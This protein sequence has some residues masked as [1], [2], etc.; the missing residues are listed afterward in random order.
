M[1]DCT[2][3]L[4]TF[5]DYCRRNPAGGSL[6]IVLEDLNLDDDSVRFCLEFAAENRD[7][8]GLELAE[9]LLRMSKTQR[10]KIARAMRQ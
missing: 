2:Q 5:Q 3:H 9:M 8:Q 4:G 1:K 7:V 10:G 6:H